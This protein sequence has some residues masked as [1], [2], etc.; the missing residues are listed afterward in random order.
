MSTPQSS[1]IAPQIIETT[2]TP[3]R[4]PEDVGV[5]KSIRRT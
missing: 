5:Q 4:L 3:S 1:G 2:Y